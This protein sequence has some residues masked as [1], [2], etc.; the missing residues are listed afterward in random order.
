MVELGAATL[1]ATD[2]RA[3]GRTWLAFMRCQV[4]YSRREAAGTWVACAPAPALTY[5]PEH[6]TA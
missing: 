2:E 6:C 1:T 3:V 5:D 4:E